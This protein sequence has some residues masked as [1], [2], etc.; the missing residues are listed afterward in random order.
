MVL[1]AVVENFG[2]L[3]ADGVM[4]SV[5]ALS[6]GVGD[7]DTIST[8]GEAVSEGDSKGSAEIVVET[9]STLVGEA[10]PLGLIDILGLMDTLMDGLYDAVGLF[11]ADSDAAGVSLID[12]VAVCD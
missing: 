5:T 11:V 8:V 6:D 3:L 7:V 10:E 9:L 2:S 4:V 1:V 12:I